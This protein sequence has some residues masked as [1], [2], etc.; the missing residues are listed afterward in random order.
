MND[1]QK[2]FTKKNLIILK[3][4]S[5]KNESYIR[6]ISEN[7]DASPAQVHQSIKIFKK[8]GFIKEKRLKNKKILS[9]KRINKAR[10][11]WYL[12][13]LRSRKRYAAKRY[14]YVDLCKKSC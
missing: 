5:S 1:L 11:C 13:K 6:E 9:I 10:N 7:T 12:W 4:L 3:D 8:L 2:V 14:R